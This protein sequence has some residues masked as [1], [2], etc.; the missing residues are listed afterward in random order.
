MAVLIVESASLELNKIWTTHNSHTDLATGPTT[1]RTTI[2]VKF[3]AAFVCMGA[4][5]LPSSKIGIKSPKPIKP[6]LARKLQVLA[7]DLIGVGSS[8]FRLD[9]AD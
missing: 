5:E 7:H 2:N 8:S 1:Q 3:D 6:F 4:R 9:I